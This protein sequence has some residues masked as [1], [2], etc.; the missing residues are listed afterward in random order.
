MSLTV[1]SNL[2]GAK[3]YAAY[4]AEKNPTEKALFE[5]EYRRIRTEEKTGGAGYGALGESLAEQN[6][7]QSGF[8][9]F[10][11][12]KANKSMQ[13]SLSSLEESKRLRAAE[14]EA[15]YEK[16]LTDYAEKK[17]K[18]REDV[19]EKIRTGGIL[20]AET[21]YRYAES[22]GLSEEEALAAAESGNAAAKAA[23]TEKIYR[24]ALEKNLSKK[25]ATAYALAL[26]FS[27][28]EADTLGNYAVG[29]ATQNFG[30]KTNDE[31]NNR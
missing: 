10:L 29:R 6:L 11:A 2:K 7:E 5:D 28:E 15:S 8:A 21:A 23:L 30:K 3:T 25:Q 4:L 17:V 27:E 20:D 12:E 9:A 1:K 14:N 13:N 24:F 16:Y 19:I 26:G 18:L 22:R 31:R